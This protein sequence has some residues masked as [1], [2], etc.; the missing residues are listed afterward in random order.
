MDYSMPGFLVFHYLSVC[1]KSWFHWVMIPSKHLILCHPFSGPQSLLGSEFFPVSQFLASGGQRIGI[2]PSASWIE[3]TWL[4]VCVCV[5][6]CSTFPFST[7]NISFYYFLACK[8]STE[9]Q[10][11]D[12]CW[13]DFLVVTFCLSLAAFRILSLTFAILIISWYEFLWV[14]IFGTH[15]Y[16]CTWISVSFLCL[17]VFRHYF[18]DTFSTF[19]SS[20][21]GKLIM[22]MLIFDA[23]WMLFQK[24]S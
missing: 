14:H 18:I 9:N 15:C 21:F 7:W 24:A 16:F 19:L 8:V 6:V 17:G 5:C 4:C 13:G 1:S 23:I 22:W 11:I 2:S 20:L 3:Y 10:L 12:S